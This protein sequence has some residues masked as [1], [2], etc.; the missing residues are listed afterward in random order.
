MAAVGPAP[1]ISTPQAEFHPVAEPSAA[2]PEADEPEL[3]DVLRNTPWSSVL[4]PLGVG[5]AAMAVSLILVFTT[6]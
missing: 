5:L 3:Q 2:K 6:K 1:V 4:V